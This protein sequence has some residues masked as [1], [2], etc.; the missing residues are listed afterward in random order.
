[1]KAFNVPSAVS[2]EPTRL[3]TYFI[4]L[5][6]D[7]RARCTVWTIN[8]ARFAGVGTPQAVNEF[9]GALN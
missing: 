7:C 5:A 8:Y 9:K 2:G 3:F 4:I 1:M 6:F